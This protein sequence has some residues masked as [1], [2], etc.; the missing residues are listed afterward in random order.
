MLEKIHSRLLILADLRAEHRSERGASATEYSL[1]I[2]FLVLALVFGVTAF[3]TELGILF[4]DL[5]DVVGLWP[6]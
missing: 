1:L 4:D 5:G 6:N 3:G 2:A